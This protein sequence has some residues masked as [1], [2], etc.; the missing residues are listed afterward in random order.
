MRTFA[1][2]QQLQEYACNALYLLAYHGNLKEHVETSIHSVFGAMKAFPDAEMLQENACMALHAMNWGWPNYEATSIIKNHAENGRIAA[3]V[4]KFPLVVNL[5]AMAF[6]CLLQDPAA[7]ADDVQRILRAMEALPTSSWLQNEAC[8]ALIRVSFSDS[9]P[10][11]A[12]SARIIKLICAAMR[13]HGPWGVPKYGSKSTVACDVL[14]A[15]CVQ[16]G[17]WN[18]TT[19]LAKEL[20]KQGG[21]DLVAAARPS[22]ECMESACTILRA[23][24]ADD[25]IEGVSDKHFLG[26]GPD[27]CKFFAAF[28]KDADDACVKAWADRAGS[29][30]RK[31][32]IA[33][34]STVSAGA[35]QELA[36]K[37]PNL[38][39]LSLNW[40]KVDDDTVKV[41]AAK[42]TKLTAISFGGCNITGASLI[43]LARKNKELTMIYLTGCKHI[44]PELISHFKADF[45]RIGTYEDTLLLGPTEWAPI[46]KNTLVGTIR[47]AVDYEV[48]FELKLLGTIE[49]Y[50]SIVHFTT[51]ADGNKYG[52]RVPG[53]WTWS[54]HKKALCLADGHEGNHNDYVQ[55]PELTIG[56]AVTVRMRVQGSARTVWFGDETVVDE[57]AKLGGARPAQEG[58]KVYIGDPWYE[59]ANALIRNLRYA[60][61]RT[62]P[63]VSESKP[64]PALAATGSGCHNCP[65]RPWHRFRC[66]S[67]IGLAGVTLSA[68]CVDQ[69]YGNPTIG[70]IAG[71]VCPAGGE[72]GDWISIIEREGTNGNGNWPRE[73]ERLQQELPLELLAAYA[74]AGEGCEL[75]LGWGGRLGRGHRIHITEAELRTWQDGKN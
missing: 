13:A 21:I 37:C 57:P 26:A 58:V 8:S 52:D 68:V 15:L 30:A 5:Q 39:R 31:A 9:N 63:D 3:A 70:K 44:T 28:P 69:E 6:A 62:L 54:G 27:S 72:P 55:T 4:D 47:T 36:R 20:A 61:I 18:A 75:E 29:N 35:I 50:G 2:S 17:G 32:G 42:W 48:S 51:D 1:D 56:E 65:V 41:M 73:K 66:A 33:S 23:L 12:V 24:A 16:T 67:P 49:G 25:E 71:R 34:S 14:C 43:E 11:A 10:P 45:P 38:T 22:G 19:S 74:E 53:V 59:P 64:P 60:S 7:E 46:A 40:T